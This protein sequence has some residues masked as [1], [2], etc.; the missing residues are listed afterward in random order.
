[1]NNALNSMCIIGNREQLQ[2]LKR[3]LKTH[4]DA[5]KNHKEAV[6]FISNTF[7]KS[8]YDEVMEITE[9]IINTSSKKI[10][11]EEK[12]ILIKTI[13]SLQMLKTLFK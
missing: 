4:A 1:M 7:I 12:E 13:H 5:I 9:D 6:D 10:P 11:K 3:E 2:Q 8:K